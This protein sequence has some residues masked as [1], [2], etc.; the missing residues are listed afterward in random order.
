MADKKT[1]FETLNGLNVNEHTEAKNGLTYLSWTWAIAEV[2]KQYPDMTYEVLM[3]DGKP[4]V[5]D[6]E[7]GYM[8]YTSVTIEG[9]TRMMWLPVMDGANR[10]MKNHPYTYKTKFG[11]KSVEQATMFD[12][13]KT[14]MRCLVKN[15]A[16]FG[17]GLY[18]YSGEDLPEEEKE[19]QKIDAKAEADEI[20]KKNKTKIT[21]GQV[22]TIKKLASEAGSEVD[23]IVKAY[24]VKSLESMSLAMFENCEKKLLSKIEAKKKETDKN[25]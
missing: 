19:Q 6:E 15:F 12:I 21:A 11:E 25:E 16:V 4:Y 18:I 3:F 9:I 10:A 17:L 1:Y 2:L 24:K 13:N 20:A 14:I 22:E 7:T 23:N 5:C 8:V